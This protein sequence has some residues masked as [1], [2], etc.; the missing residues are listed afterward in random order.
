MI[1]MIILSGFFSKTFCSEFFSCLFFFACRCFTTCNLLLRASQEQ[2]W[3]GHWEVWRTA[4]AVVQESPNVPSFLATGL[5]PTSVSFFSFFSFFS[6]L[7][8][9][10]S[11]S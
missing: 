1:G 5:S 6:F 10:C 4:Y 8:F 9:L 3:Q 7:S 11:L 2:N